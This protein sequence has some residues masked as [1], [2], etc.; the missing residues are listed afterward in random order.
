MTDART[1]CSQVLKEPCT[2]LPHSLLVRLYRP[3]F[4]TETRQLTH[5]STKFGIRIAFPSQQMTKELQSYLSELEK[6]KGIRI[7][8]TDDEQP[9]SIGL[10][11]QQD[12]PGKKA[13]GWIFWT[14]VA[15]LCTVCAMLM[16]WAEA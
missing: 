4:R 1:R 10:S 5:S 7:A 13:F 14:A 6:L 12:A 11:Y 3:P 16:W 8:M 15:I 2:T 9:L